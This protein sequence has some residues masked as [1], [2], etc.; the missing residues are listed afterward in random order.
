MI[1]MF[2][3]TPSFAAVS[4]I[5][6]SVSATASGGGSA[7]A[8]VRTIVNGETIEDIE[9]ADENSASIHVESKTV[10]GE[11]TTNVATTASQVLGENV[12][13]QQTA[14]EL[15][16]TLKQLFVLLQQYYAILF[17]TAS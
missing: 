4:S 11:T 2:P 8:S 6:N 9:I 10:D 3:V 16:A 13:T 7:T 15:N 1:A 17:N 14:D 12:S 5:S